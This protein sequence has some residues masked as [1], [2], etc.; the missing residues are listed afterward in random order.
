MYPPNGRTWKINTNVVWTYPEP[1]EHGE[2]YAKHEQNTLTQVVV[3]PVQ[4]PTQMRVNFDQLDENHPE[5][6]NMQGELSSA[7]FLSM[8]I[9]NNTRT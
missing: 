6:Q 4:K 7:L 8:A 2:R 1:C 3:G 9:S 5:V